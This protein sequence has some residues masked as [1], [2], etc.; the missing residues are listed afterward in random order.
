MLLPLG[1]SKSFAYQS[2]QFSIVQ[3]H[4][5]LLENFRRTIPRSNPTATS[6]SFCISLPRSMLQKAFTG[7]I[8]FLKKDSQPLPC[9]K[10]GPS[11]KQSPQ[12]FLLQQWSRYRGRVL[13]WRAKQRSPGLV[14]ERQKNLHAHNIRISHVGPDTLNSVRDEDT[15]ET[16][17]TSAQLGFT[18]KPRA[19]AIAPGS[20][21]L[22]A[23]VTVQDYACRSASS[24][25]VPFGD[26]EQRSCHT[27]PIFPRPHQK[28]RL[29]ITC[30]QF[31][32]VCVSSPRLFH[33]C[34]IGLIRSIIS[35]STLIWLLFK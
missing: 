16:S 5:F 18:S 11:Q 4:W 14:T 25:P 6:S 28:G 3:N 21:W 12:T 30:L 17:Q 13:Q 32:T 8:C 26:E 24:S 29:E 1:L 10:S 23:M 35:R 7:K 9:E 15:P 31:S 27:G 34:V 22:T 19:A 2:W 20:G 33:G